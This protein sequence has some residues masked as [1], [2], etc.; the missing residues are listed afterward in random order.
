[1][2]VTPD[3]ILSQAV[4]ALDNADSSEVDWRCATS[5]AYYAA[6]HRCRAVAESA[7]LAVPER[8]SVHAWLIEALTAPRNPGRMRGLGY[9]LDQARR[10]RVEADYEIDIPFE[11][12]EATAAIAA[13]RKLFEGADALGDS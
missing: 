11:R 8:G 10:W 6:Y 4:H 1:M 2:A 5:R 3:Q 9:I 7:S 13:C 12:A